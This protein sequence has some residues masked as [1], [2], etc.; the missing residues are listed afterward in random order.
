MR[1]L[2]TSERG[3][4]LLEVM[5]GIVLL[6]FGLL[7]VADVFSRGL[8]LGLYGEDQTRGAGLAQQQVEFLKT[9]PTS[10][11]PCPATPI[12]QTTS[13]GLNCLVGDYA[14]AVSTS[15]FDINGTPT[16]AATAY[17]SRDVQVQ[18]WPWNGVTSQF[19]GT[20]PYI[21]PGGPYVFRV[22]VATHWLVRGKT[23]WVSGQPVG[24]NGC[25]VA[26]TVVTTSLGCLQVST[27]VSP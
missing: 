19:V 10:A 3:F 14:V 7:A 23:T 9:V 5:V 18:Y 20:A 1:G 22:T 27:F 17:Y 21:V 11:S 15:Y 16:V 8:A 26:A 12:A 25:I 13:T 24:S 6:A 2:I 4:T